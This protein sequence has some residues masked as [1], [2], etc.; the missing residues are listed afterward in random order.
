MDCRIFLTKL[1]ELLAGFLVRKP[2]SKTA[3]DNI[4]PEQNTGQ[5]AAC[6]RL[7]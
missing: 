5:N 4:S 3:S 6:R 2:D 1:P 7:F